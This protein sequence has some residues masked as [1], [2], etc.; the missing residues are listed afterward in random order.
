MD[1]HGERTH[2]DAMVDVIRVKPTDKQ[3]VAQCI[4]LERKCFAKHEAMDVL[5]ETRGRN[6]V[7]LCAVRGEGQTGVC[8]GYAVLQRTGGT[9][10]VVKL[11]VTPALRRLGIGTALMSRAVSVARQ[12]RAT[13]CCLHVDESNVVAQHL[14]HSLGFRATDRRADFYRPGRHALFMELQFGDTEQV[15]PPRR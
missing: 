15:V 5:K 12:Q 7:L 13:I 11:V 10:A 2:S 6:S 4:A 1:G 3:L 8:A 9:A 14:Y